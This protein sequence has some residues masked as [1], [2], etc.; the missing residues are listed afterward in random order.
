MVPSHDSNPRTVNRKSDALPIAPPRHPHTWPNF[1]EIC[2]NICEE[3]VFTRFFGSLPAVTLTFD[4][5]APKSNQYIYECKYVCDYN[6]IKLP[7]LVGIWE[8]WCHLT[9][10]TLTFN[11]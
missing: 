11:L 5:L 2:T 8:I 7:S 6:K 9:F 3:I 10:M 4:F 1:G